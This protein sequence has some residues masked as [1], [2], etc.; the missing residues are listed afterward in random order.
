MADALIR[1]RRT[2][3]YDPDDP[4]PFSKQELSQV[5]PILACDSG[6]ERSFHVCYE[7]GERKLPRSVTWKFRRGSRGRASRRSLDLPG[8][9]APRA[10]L[11]L[12]DLA[13][14]P[15]DARDL[16]VGLPGAA[17]LVVG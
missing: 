2:P 12:D 7:K 10:D 11:H 3:P 9:Q 17:R 15:D 16:K 14:G 8:V 1:R 13:L 5:R 6:D 4:V